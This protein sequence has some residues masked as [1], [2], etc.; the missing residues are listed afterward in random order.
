MKKQNKNSFQNSIL[1]LQIYDYVVQTNER[2]DNVLK[3]TQK[4]I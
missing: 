1:T 4:R 2:F 3:M